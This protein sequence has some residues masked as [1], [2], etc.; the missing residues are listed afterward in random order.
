[1]E[2]NRGSSFESRKSLN[3]TGG[4]DHATREA[5]NTPRCGVPAASNV[6]VPISIRTFGIPNEWSQPTVAWRSPD[7][8]PPEVSQ[9]QAAEAARAAFNQWRNE[10]SREFTEL[11]SGTADIQITFG[12]PSVAGRSRRVRRS[13]QRGD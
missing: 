10:T 1:M 13:N 2:R 9:P 5:V 4:V 7:G 12:T 11:T 8:A 6:Q 3:M